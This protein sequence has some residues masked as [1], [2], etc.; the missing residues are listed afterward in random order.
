MI[1]DPDDWGG[2][3][4]DPPSGNPTPAED[5]APPPPADADEGPWYDA[6]RDL[7]KQSHQERVAKNPDRVAYAKQQFEK[8]GIEH[9]LKN[10][11][12]GHF[13]CYRKSDGALFQFYAGTGKI[14]GESNK[15]GIDAMIRILLS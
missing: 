11:V 10:S 8:N 2:Y 13:H 12:T 14:M 6:Y 4:P 3:W 1:V 9:Y 5:F 15:R 7:A